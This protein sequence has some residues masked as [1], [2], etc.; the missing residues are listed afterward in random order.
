M[1]ASRLSG[2]VRSCVF[3]MRLFFANCVLFCSVL[4]AQDVPKQWPALASDG[5]DFPVG[6]PNAEGYYKAR[7]YWPNGHLGEDW[8][9]K[10]GGDTDLGDPVYACSNG[11]VVF[12]QNFA[13]GWGNVLIIRHVFEEDGQRKYVD[14]LYGHLDQIQVRYGQHV[15]RGQQIGT[16]GTGGGLYDAHLH[17]EIRRELRLGMARHRF[18]RDDRSYWSPTDFINARRKLT[19]SAQTMQV[20]VNNFVDYNLPY[21]ADAAVLPDTEKSQVE[22]LKKR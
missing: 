21:P 3:S 9:G 16:I 22:T 8:N 10:G 6:K 7:G 5:F 20:P 19:P 2:A 4:C 13:R 17:F 15:R 12:A 11:L 14:S 18:P 1:L